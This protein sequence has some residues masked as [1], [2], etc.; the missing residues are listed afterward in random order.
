M[1]LSVAL[2][3]PPGWEAIPAVTT[4][5]ANGLDPA[6]SQGPSG[7][8]PNQVRG[9][10][11]LGTYASG[12]L[13]NCVTFGAQGTIQGDGSGQTIAIVD[14]YDD[15]GLVSSSDPNFSTSDLAEFDAQFGLPDPP[16]FK[17]LNQTGG[18]KL[19]TG[20]G[21]GWVMEESLDV[22]WAH[23]MAPMANII[24]YEAAD[25]G[26]GL[27]TAVHTAASH[28]GVDVHLDE[29]ERAR[30]LRR[31]RRRLHFYHP[32]RARR[33]RRVGRWQR[34]DRRHHLPGFHR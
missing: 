34:P 26:D 30:V 19:P 11:G 7:L 3:L 27:Y 21:T 18:T 6:G 8:T 20:S 1:L 16:S 23:A 33:R 10:Y 28:S 32:D 24:L 5:L 12:V 29:L 25:T 2:S 17:K 4:A 15:P 14:A 31:D 22:E 13:T 9:A